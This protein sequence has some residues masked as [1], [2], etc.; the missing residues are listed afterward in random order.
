MT[1]A[2]TKVMTARHM[3][4]NRM[5][6]SMESLRAGAAFE[7]LGRRTEGVGQGRRLLPPLD[8]RDQAGGN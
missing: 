1:K 4:G 2:P 7:H 5:A 8:D 6:S 3:I